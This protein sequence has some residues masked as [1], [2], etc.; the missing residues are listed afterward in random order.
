MSERLILEAEPRSVVGKQVKQLRRGGWIPASV[1]GRGSNYNIQIENLQ[2]RRVLR[3]AGTTSL[4]EIKIGEASHTV[5]AREIQA[6]PTRGD[7]IHVDFYEV[8][9]QELISVEATVV[10]IGAPSLEL[11]GLGSINQTLYAIEIET[12]PGNLISEVE[13]DLVAFQ[14]PEDVVYASDLDLPEGVALLTNPEM[15]VA[16]FEYTP[17]AEEEVTEEEEESLF[18]ESA[19]VEVIGKGKDEE[20]EVA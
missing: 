2:L 10:L 13:L 9:M 16:R 7:L 18:A 12:L 15:A 8:N 1:Y 4:V 6:H 17:V 19:E 14:S 5:L 20:E 11:E 3:S